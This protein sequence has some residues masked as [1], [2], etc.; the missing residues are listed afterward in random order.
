MN[1]TL[2]K[3]ERERSKKVYFPEYAREFINQEGPGV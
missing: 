1:R 3:M 2:Y